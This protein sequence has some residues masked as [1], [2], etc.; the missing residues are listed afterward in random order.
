MPARMCVGV[1][2]C[3]CV[4]PEVRDHLLILVHRENMFSREEVTYD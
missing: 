4:F 1:G 2:V 3:V